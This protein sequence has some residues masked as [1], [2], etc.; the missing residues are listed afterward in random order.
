MAKA[1]FK[2]HT[3]LRVRWMECDAQRIVYNGSYMDYLEVG[4]AEYYRNLGFSIYQV[5]ESS[6]FDT[7]VVKV[8]L[9][10]KAPARVENILDI[11]MRVSSIGNTSI[12]MDMEIYAQGTEWLLTTGQA[13][14]VGYDASAGTTKGIPPDIRE[15]I[16]HYEM[17]GVA[18]PLATFPELA[19]AA[20]WKPGS[21]DQRS[22]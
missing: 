2:F 12:T 13:V 15:V 20:A 17:N 14:Y 10:Y 6:Y 16:N 3:S 4:Q 22:T 21:D 18:L 11:Y 1:D 19:A 9:E 7:A 5:A 8:T